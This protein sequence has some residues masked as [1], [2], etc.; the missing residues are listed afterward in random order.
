MPT[1]RKS[2]RA[3][4]RRR[5]PTARR[6][7]RVTRRRRGGPFVRPAKRLAGTSKMP[8]A[9]YSRVLEG[10]DILLSVANQVD[11]GYWNIQQYVIPNSIPG[12]SILKDMYR[13]FRIKSVTIQ[14]TPAYRSDE[15]SKLFAHPSAGTQQLFN[16]NG[17]VL[18]I[19][20]LTDFG[21]LTAAQLQT[22]SLCLN[23]AGKIRRCATTK[24]F[25]IK[26]RP[27]VRL[28]MND[29]DPATADPEELVTPGWMSTQN[30]ANLAQQYLLGTDCFHSMNNVSY[31]NSFPME[32]ARRYVIEVEFKG[33]LI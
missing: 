21:N 15:F 11:P 12:I 10:G 28:E 13:Y 9:K 20:H 23:K 3:T 22:W 6:V 33:L 8:Y 17:G 14:Y 18:E 32:I 19:K 25:T 4:R 26:R 1:R 31:D 27:K 5:G 29:D 7:T 2:T 16:A 24:P 30:S